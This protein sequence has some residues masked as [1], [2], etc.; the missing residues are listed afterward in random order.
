MQAY[1]KHVFS[2][3]F[4]SV[5]YGR[6]SASIDVLELLPNGTIP[7]PAGTRRVFVEVGANSANTVD[8]EELSMFSDAFLV[9]FEFLLHQY[10]ALLSLWGGADGHIF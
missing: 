5:Q 3:G 4:C 9:S 6:L 7:V 8:E 1:P 10:A 2:W